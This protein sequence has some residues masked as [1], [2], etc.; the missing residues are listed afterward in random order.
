MREHVRPPIGD[1]GRVQARARVSV[2]LPPA[3]HDEHGPTE[4][5]QGIEQGGPDQVPRPREPFKEA[6][7]PFVQRRP[8]QA[9]VA[10]GTLLPVAG[11]D[12]PALCVPPDDEGIGEGESQQSRPVH[13][14]PRAEAPAFG[15]RG[16]EPS[17]GE[18]QR[19]QGDGVLL[20]GKAQPHQQARPE[21][22]PRVDR[23]Q[24]A[25]DKSDEQ[26]VGERGAREQDLK[27]RTGREKHRPECRPAIVESGAQG[28][29]EGDVE[30]ARRQVGQASRHL[31]PPQRAHAGCQEVE[32]EGRLV[33]RHLKQIG[34]A[35][36]DAQCP[37]GIERF[38]G[39][40][41]VLGQIDH[42]QEKARQQ[43]RDGEDCRHPGCVPLAHGGY[44]SRPAGSGQPLGEP[45]ENSGFDS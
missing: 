3:L 13:R 43:E 24:G 12:G 16:L 29:D 14:A 41:A 8:G 39:V 23:D 38:V 35:I 26:R 10:H 6:R 19:D 42:A 21:P 32:V 27:G 37:P 2:P 17:H 45:L 34:I 40:K 33:N 25:K 7:A 30:H 9:A 20:G 4:C 31:A 22:T 15:P 5:E 28:I 44:Y 1:K 36:Q 18:H 11:A